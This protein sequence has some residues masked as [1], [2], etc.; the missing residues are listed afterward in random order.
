MQ[1]IM[2]NFALIK[3]IHV[4]S[5]IASASLFFLRGIWMIQESANLNLRWVKTSP[6]MIDTIL[7]LSAILLSIGLQQYPFVD[8]W[9]TA[10]VVA[11]LV[12][13]G[14]GTVAIRR[15]RTRQVRIVNWICALGVL[16]YIIGVATTRSASLGL[17]N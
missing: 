6:H 10:K 5:V 16:A 13:I 14:L 2:N 1:W 12:Y 9:L 7:L 15:G 4:T 11:L 17:L 8:G 3:A